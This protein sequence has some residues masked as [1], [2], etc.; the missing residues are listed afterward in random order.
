MME[1]ISMERKTPN[2]LDELLFGAV[3]CHGD[4]LKV[5]NANSSIIQSIK[6]LLALGAN[7]SS[8]IDSRHVKLGSW[9]NAIIVAAADGHGKL[10]SLLLASPLAEV[11]A[12]NSAGETAL[13]VAARLRHPKACAMLAAA[14][15]SANIQDCGGL[16]ALM[17]AALIGDYESS[18][19]LA[20]LTDLSSK[21]IHGSTVLAMAREKEIVE[22]LAAHEEAK[23]IA[24][25]IPCPSG[26]LG[27]AKAKTRSL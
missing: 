22:L 21:S 25:E 19:I 12:Q 5:G 1:K 6:E 26:S 11:D 27:Q 18:A 10:L 13:I 9:N 20:P 3:A 24:G 23:I 8:M 16:T 15:A 17:A 7:P 4:L 2:R 14:G